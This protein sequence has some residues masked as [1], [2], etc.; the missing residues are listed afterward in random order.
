MAINMA[1]PGELYFNTTNKKQEELE[2]GQKEERL[3]R[4][5]LQ[6]VEGELNGKRE[7]RGTSY[8][9]GEHVGVSGWS[10]WDSPFTLSPPLRPFPLLSPHEPWV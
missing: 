2:E 7:N 6:T 5:E 9:G 1:L 3:E 8:G 4:V 10:L